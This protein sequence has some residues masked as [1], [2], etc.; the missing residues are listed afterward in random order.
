MKP[1]T[2]RQ[3]DTAMQSETIII[4]APTKIVTVYG[5]DSYFGA[6]LVKHLDLTEQMVYG[7]SQDRDLNFEEEP[8]LIH[9]REKIAFEPAP[10]VSDWIIV[11]LDPRI[12]LD[13]YIIRMKNLCN[14]LVD[15]EFLGK[16]CFVS[17]GGICLSSDKE[18]SEDTVVYPRTQSDLALSIGENFL[19]VML[20][21]KDNQAGTLV[22]R[23]GVPY[24]DEVGM[25][26]ATG[27]IN[28]L[29][30]STSAGQMLEI[31]GPAEVKRSCTHISDICESIISLL[32]AGDLAPSLVNIPGE[33]LT[34]QDIITTVTER[35]P[36]NITYRL[37]END[38]SDFYIGDQHLSDVYFKENSAFKRKY[39]FKEWFNNTFPNEPVKVKA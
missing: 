38:D 26:D 28:R 23:V 37:C 11:C 1:I 15:Q 14:Y 25:S 18:I 33:T 9:G 3:R 36:V 22:V 13:V 24:G 27:M 30:K 12:S 21:Q 20:H 10:V 29:I 17:S 35:F 7:F 34:V 39:A 6:H 31:P 8:M 4:T 5:A 16:V 19:N 32:P 2:A